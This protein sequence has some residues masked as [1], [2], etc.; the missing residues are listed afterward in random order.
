MRKIVKT[1]N[2][3]SREIPESR[4]F[5]S[6][7]GEVNCTYT[8]RVVWFDG[9]TMMGGDECVFPE[10]KDCKNGGLYYGPCMVASVAD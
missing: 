8:G 6:E 5:T 1:K 2:V 7:N 3:I 4:I 9:A 10:Y